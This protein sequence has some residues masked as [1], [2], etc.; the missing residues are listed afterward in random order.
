MYIYI[1]SGN[2]LHSHGKSPFLIGTPSISMGHLYHGELLNNQRV[3]IVYT[4]GYRYP[5]SL[6]NFCPSN[7]QKLGS[8][9]REV[10][11]K[12]HFF[13]LN[14]CPYHPKFQ[15]GTP[16]IWFTQHVPKQSAEPSRKPDPK[17]KQRLGCRWMPKP[18]LDGHQPLLAIVTIGW[19]FFHGRFGVDIPS[20]SRDVPSNSQNS[21]EVGKGLSGSPNFPYT[22]CGS[23]GGSAK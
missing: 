20:G 21:W 19:A 3:Y 11:E 18:N 1:P 12:P 22:A 7:S 16:K 15:N 10:M 9:S 2:L 23:P 13:P 17:R 8:S 14:T 4:D 5:K 6:P